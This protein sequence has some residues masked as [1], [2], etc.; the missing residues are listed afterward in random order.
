MAFY[1]SAYISDGDSRARAAEAEA[2]RVEW[3]RFAALGDGCRRCEGAGQVPLGSVVTV[4]PGDTTQTHVLCP[5]CLG[6]GK[7]PA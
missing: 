5:R 7:E 4:R 2:M 6:V 3:D 1:L